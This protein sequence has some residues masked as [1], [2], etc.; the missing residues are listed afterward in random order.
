MNI[1]RRVYEC[2]GAFVA[3]RKSYILSNVSVGDSIRFEE[4]PSNYYDTL[5]IKILHGRK[6]IGYVGRE[7]HAYIDHL[8]Y[9]DYEA[10]IHKISFNGT[11]ID[12]Y[13]KILSCDNPTF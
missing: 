7:D 13:Y 3:D 10:V 8:L 12:V 1:L 6:K 4:E 9:Q 11:Y 2:K 5:A